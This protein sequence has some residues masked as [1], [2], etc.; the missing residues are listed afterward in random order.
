MTDYYPD[1]LSSHLGILEATYQ[2]PTF[3]SELKELEN[4][5][6]T[7]VE[8]L[9]K[10]AEFGFEIICMEVLKDYDGMLTNIT[11]F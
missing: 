4:Y 5:A 2:P 7:N 8:V 11:I 6:R 10:A 9:S 1:V 3:R